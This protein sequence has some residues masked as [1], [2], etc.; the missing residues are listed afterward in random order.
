MRKEITFVILLLL[1]G[2]S[3]LTAQIKSDLPLIKPEI[4]FFPEITGFPA[5]STAVCSENIKKSGALH[6]F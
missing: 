5:K 2:L 4:P 6:S 1:V 3:S